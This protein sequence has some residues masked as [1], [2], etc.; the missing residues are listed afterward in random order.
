MMRFF[1]VA[2]M[3]LFT[4]T[5]FAQVN[6]LSHRGYYT[7]DGKIVTDENSLD[8]LKRAQ[9]ANLYSIEF[10][11]HLTADDK[12]VIHHDTKID[13]NLNCQKSTF[14]EIR[15]YRL[16]FGNQIPSLEEWLTQA[17]KHPTLQYVIEIKKHSWKR[18]KKLLQ[19]VVDAVHAHNL[20]DRV[21]YVSF[22]L[23]TCKE[24]LKIDPKA[25]V[26]FNSANVHE[27]L[28]PDD[29]KALGFYGISYRIDVFLNH[30]EWL[31]RCQEIDL[32]SFF[33][34]VNSKYL[35]DLGMDLGVSIVTT[36]YA[37]VIAKYI[38][39]HKKK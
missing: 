38:E 6:I 3:M 21:G 35:V 24:L 4:I 27:T 5:A 18:E 39:E 31:K 26:T 8:A 37:D 15:K 25:R 2:A 1:T 28:T 19:M 16:P 32:K 12:I 14:D 23:E 20:Q 30:V 17:E 7:K 33:W 10:D 13:G 34:M 11:V 36:D 22:R 29:A 9:E